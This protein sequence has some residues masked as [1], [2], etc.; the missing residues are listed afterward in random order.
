MVYEQ[1]LTS[2]ADCDDPLELSDHIEKQTLFRYIHDWDKISELVKTRDAREVIALFPAAAAAAVCVCVCVCCMLIP[3]CCWHSVDVAQV[4]S[5]KRG[6]KKKKSMFRISRLV[7]ALT[8][9]LLQF[10][11]SFVS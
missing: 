8:S 6:A 3:W 1:V 4:T 9:S 2:I 10:P 7:S 5:R 11:R